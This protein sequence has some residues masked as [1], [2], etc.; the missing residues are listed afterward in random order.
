M[1]TMI[2]PYLSNII[3]DHK[4]QGEWK[5]Q[6]TMSIN[7]ISSE[8]DSDEVC[9]VHTKSDNIE[10][11]MGSETD[12]IIEELFKSL[13]KR[14]QEGLEESMRGTEFIFDRVD[15]LYYNLNEISLSK[16]GSYIDPPKWLK[17]KKTTINPK[18]NDDKCFQ[19]GLTVALNYQNIKN[20]PE[21]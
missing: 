12:E 5:I 20:I 10:I 19:Y 8:E 16:G 21:N 13:L 6:L 18:N 9:T 4:T 7:F 2:R 1:N 15:A 11:M 17:N 3:N 14:Y